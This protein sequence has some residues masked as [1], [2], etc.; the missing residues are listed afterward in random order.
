MQTFKRRQTVYIVRFSCKNELS[1]FFSRNINPHKH[2]TQTHKY[3]AKHRKKQLNIVKE[4]L[5]KKKKL[6]KNVHQK[7]KTRLYKHTKAY[8]NKTNLLAEQKI[9]DG[10]RYRGKKASSWNQT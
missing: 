8:Q 7:I 2:I 1:L 9:T 4:C 3:Y 6:V 5:G 10:R